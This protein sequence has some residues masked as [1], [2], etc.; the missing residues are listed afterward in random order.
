MKEMKKGHTCCLCGKYEENQYRDELASVL[1][2]L[3]LCHT[4]N[5]WREHFEE[6]LFKRPKYSWCISNGVHY[7]IGPEN[8]NTMFRGFGGA[9]VTIKFFDGTVRETTNLWCQGDITKPWDEV[10]KDNATLKFGH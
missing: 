1:A 6:D 9:H 8:D 10:M 4:C 7:V 3:K 5:F 2:G